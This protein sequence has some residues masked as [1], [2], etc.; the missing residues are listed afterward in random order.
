MAKAQI[1]VVEDEELV[2]MAIQAHLESIGY[3][4]P[5]LASSGEE[6][7][8]HFR[9]HEPD[10]VLMDIHLKGTMSGIEVADRIKDSYHVPVIYL[11]AYS[12]P[13]TLEF[14]KRTEP[15][16]YIVKPI[17]ERSLE[18]GIEM[19]LHKSAVQNE[20]QRLRERMASILGSLPEA[21]V[22]ADMNGV[23]EYLN[24]SAERLLGL[25]EPLPP[26]SSLFRLIRPVDADTGQPMSL[27]FE[28]VVMERRGNKV[29]R[30]HIVLPQGQSRSVSI[31]ME[32]RK[33]DRGVLRGVVV[34]IRPAADA[35]WTWVSD[36]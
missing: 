25:Y 22:V 15:Y 17:D 29:S 7:L 11:T 31:E 2:G 14:A 33:D 6:A 4:V 36:N 20:E 21:V 13:A 26:N 9:E 3:S 19:A 32:P 16:G 1:L 24:S 10:L 27:G 34:T 35:D 5:L 28:Q 12:D 23:V 8:A 18:A 30:C